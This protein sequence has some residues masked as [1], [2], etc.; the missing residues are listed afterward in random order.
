MFAKT[1]KKMLL[2][3]LSVVALQASA[4]DATITM[5]YSNDSVKLSDYSEVYIRSLNIK[6]AKLV[7]APW[8][9]QE[10]AAW[11]ARHDNVDFLNTQYKTALTAALTKNNRFK[12]ATYEGK[13]VLVLDTTL[14]R[15]TPYA[16]PNDK[17]VITKG[18]GELN[19]LVQLRDGR[20]GELIF[21]AEGIQN[22]GNEYQ[23][24]SEMAVIKHTEAL[25][26]Q[27]GAGLVN[28]L[29]SDED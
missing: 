27:W 4:S 16:E 23:P 7:P 15:F 3:L 2:P 21:I 13:G 5:K 12:I 1:I 18:A 8:L 25:F 22:V 28:G 24:N 17:E 20:T 10:A 19:F 14:I 9:E 11:N 6:G 29:T 26:E